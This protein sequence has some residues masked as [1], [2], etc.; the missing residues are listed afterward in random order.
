MTSS[1]APGEDITAATVTPVHRAE[2]VSFVR[3]SARMTHLQQQAWDDNVATML[4]D[5]P[6]AFAQ[7]SVHPDFE[8]DITSAFGRKA[9]LV[10]EIG[11]G[12]GEAIVNAA[13]NSPERNFLAVEVY[14]PG[15]ALTMMRAAKA[16]VTNLRLIQANAP[17]V[18]QSALPEASVNELWVFFA[19][20]WHKKR[21]YKRRLIRPSF[22]PQMERVL[23]DAATLRL[24]TDWEHYA[25]HIR[26]VLVDAD[27]LIT[28][29][30]DGGWSPRFEGRCLTSFERK[31]LE[32]GREV[33][34]LTYVRTSTN[35]TRPRNV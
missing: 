22:I 4:I 12:L 27:H 35:T 14:T 9:P 34:D 28:T 3:R 26:D 16:G 19:D 20:P 33:R 10:V 21:H 31:A 23:A 30:P 32:A 8:L 11:S 5:V 13:A 25:E 29:D 17:E 2:P 1:S 15:L 24:A 7:T 6:R 18:L